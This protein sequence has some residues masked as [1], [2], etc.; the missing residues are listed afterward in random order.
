MSASSSTITMSEAMLSLARSLAHTCLLVHDR[1]GREHHSHPRTSRTRRFLR[2]IVQ[3]DPSS[4][5]FQNLPDNGETK[6]RALLPRG[7]VGFEQPP[8]IFL[9]QSDA[10]VDDVEDDIMPL[11]RC[12]YLDFSAAELLRRHCG[13]RFRSV[14]DDVG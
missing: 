4:V 5:L 11:A 8:P 2:R 7:D 3:F 14:L 9:R 6:A 10:V 13:D 12:R 1:F